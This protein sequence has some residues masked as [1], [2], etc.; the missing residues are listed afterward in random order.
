MMKR[1]GHQAYLYLGLLVLASVLALA[2]SLAAQCNR[3]LYFGKTSVFADN[4]P[5][6]Y[7]VVLGAMTQSGYAAVTRNPD[8]ITGSKNGVYVSVTCVATLPRVT[9]VVM[10][11]GEVDTATKQIRDELRDKIAGTKGL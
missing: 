2:T 8:E 9:A 4:M 1:F 6:C 7:S 11:M 5:T 3:Y 10:A